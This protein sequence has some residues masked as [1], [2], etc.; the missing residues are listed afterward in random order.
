MY[1]NSTE[2]DNNYMGTFRI[3]NTRAMTGCLNL[4]KNKNLT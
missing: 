2:H 3:T 1:N 4:W